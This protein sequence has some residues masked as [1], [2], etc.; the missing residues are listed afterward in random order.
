MTAAP[1]AEPASVVTVTNELIAEFG[2]LFSR[3][4]VSQVPVMPCSSR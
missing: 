3:S 1:Q 2:A 4:V